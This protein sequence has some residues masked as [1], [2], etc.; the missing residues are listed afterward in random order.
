MKI[1]ICV[2]A[3]KLDGNAAVAVSWAEILHE[4]GHEVT[5]LTPQVAPEGRSLIPAGVRLVPIRQGLWESPA[6]LVRRLGRTFAQARFDV[7]F[8]LTGLPIPGLERAYPAIPQET[9]LVQVVL[10]DRE[11]V[12]EPLVRC[13]DL[14]NVALVI[15]PALERQV[16][17]RVPGRP[18]ELVHLAVDAPSSPV[19]IERATP[20]APLRLI[21]VGRLFGRKNV[22]LLPPILA[23]CQRAGVPVTLTVVG[24]GPDRRPLMRSCR[25][26]GVLDCVSFHR[27][28]SKDALTQAF[29]Q[30]DVLVWTAGQGEGLGLVLLEAQAHGCVPVATHLPGVSDFAIAH[31]H[32]GLLARPGDPE[33]FARQI[34]RLAE[35]GLRQSLASAGMARVRDQFS[36]E[37]LAGE[38]NR[39]LEEIRGGA[40]RLTRPRDSHP[41]DRPSWRDRLPRAFR[42]VSRPRRERPDTPRPG[43]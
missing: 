38:L 4:A 25:Q 9:V 17:E 23:A 34:L 24:D 42:R 22:L 5:L 6:G 43:P 30:H 15:S 16:Q 26:L 28:P 12:Y 21:T 2:W 27:I 29:A 39:L 33:D 18:V 1:G 3:L 8:V 40:Y 11:H 13:R 35:P 36:R 7:L 20:G 32:T 19:P 14:W 37:R 31:E 41:I 10:G